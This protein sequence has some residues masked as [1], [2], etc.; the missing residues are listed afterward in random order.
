MAI[1]RKRNK[2]NGIS[3]TVKIQESECSNSPSWI[4]R[5]VGRVTSDRH[6]T[7]LRPTENPPRVSFSTFF[8]VKESGYKLRLPNYTK[9]T[10]N[11]NILHQNTYFDALN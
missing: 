5:G 4:I 6:L 10:I 9:L 2:T 7:G 11:K 1:S 3:R 8:A